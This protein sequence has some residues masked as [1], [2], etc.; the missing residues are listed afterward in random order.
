MLM[1][2]LGF[3]AG[4]LFGGLFMA[5]IASGARADRDLEWSLLLDRAKQE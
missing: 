1:F 4:G 5:A 2:L 3:M